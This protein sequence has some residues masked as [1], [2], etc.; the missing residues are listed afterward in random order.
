VADAYRVWSDVEETAVV[1]VLQQAWT[2]RL[3]P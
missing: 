3:S 1:A 2:A